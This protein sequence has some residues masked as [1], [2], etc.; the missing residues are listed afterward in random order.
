MPHEWLTYIKE[1]V[2]NLSKELEELRSIN[3]SAPAIKKAIAIK[4]QQIKELNDYLDKKT[5]KK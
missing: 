5:M 3:S 1:L 2:S 4:E